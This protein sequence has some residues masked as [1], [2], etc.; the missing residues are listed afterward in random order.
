PAMRPATAIAPAYGAAGSPVV[1]TTRM[2]GALVTRTSPSL[3]LRAAFGMPA[4]LDTAHPPPHG[5][6]SDWNCATS[7]SSRAALRGLGSGRSTQLMTA[8][9]STTEF[10]VPSGLR[11]R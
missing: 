4:Q 10:H 11:P 6:R 7:A 3:S 1:P 5:G 8:F 2:G 9:A